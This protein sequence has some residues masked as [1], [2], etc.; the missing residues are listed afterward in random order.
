[1]KHI[2]CVGAC[3]LD[4]I[5]TVPKFPT[6][7]SKL[8]ATKLTRRLGGNCPNTLSVLEQFID[9]SIELHFLAVLP[10]EHS[11]AT[12]FIR[13]SYSKVQIDPSCIY[14]VAYDESPSSYIFQNGETNSRTI[15]NYN[16]LPEMTKEEFV[17]QAHLLSVSKE[18]VEGWYHFEG[19]IPDIILHGIKYLRASLPGFKISVEAE[20][21]GREGLQ[22]LASA[23]DAVFFSRSWAEGHNYSS[24]KECLTAQATLTLPDALL[25]CTWGS[26]GAV[27][28]QKSGD[29]T[30]VWQS[31][32]AWTMKTR[33]VRDTIGAGDTFIAGMLFA[34]SHHGENWSLKQKLEFANELAG[35]KV[36]QEGF[37]DLA[38]QMGLNTKLPWY[39][40]KLA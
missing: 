13:D 40:P 38:G 23:A 5:L 12:K 19:R 21:P 18:A 10:S 17:H 36:I 22:E 1:M 31:V 7:D 15:V 28:L 20:K 4:T 11:G 27:A 26:A 2:I 24:A 16:E 25:C 9:E 29:G 37:A 30:E 32:N 34:L 39:T 8:R 6:E 14:R 33:E 35:R 3:Y